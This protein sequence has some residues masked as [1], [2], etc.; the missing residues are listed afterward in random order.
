[1]VWTS[2]FLNNIFFFFIK[3][4]FWVYI[5]INDTTTLFGLFF[6]RLWPFF[7][8]LWLIGYSFNFYFRYFKSCYGTFSFIINVVCAIFWYRIYVPGSVYFK[9]NIFIEFF[10]N[11]CYFFIFCLWFFPYIDCLGINRAFFFIISKFLCNANL[12]Y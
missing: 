9:I 10:R 2:R 3:Y 11:K 7:F 8:Y 6:F 1:M 12:Y 5:Y 4:L